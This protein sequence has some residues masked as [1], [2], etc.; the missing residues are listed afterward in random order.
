MPDDQQVG[1]DPDAF[2]QQFVSSQGATP[3]DPDE[4]HAKYASQAQPDAIGKQSK[5]AAIA[6]GVTNPGAA[7]IPTP[8]P[9]RPFGTRFKEFLGNVFNPPLRKPE[10]PYTEANPGPG[11]ATA[12]GTKIPLRD[13][14]SEA[15]SVASFGVGMGEGA[16]GMPRANI[17]GLVGDVASVSGEGAKAIGRGVS[18]TVKGVGDLASRAVREPGRYTADPSVPPTRG[19]LKP[20]AK[21]GVGPANISKF[22]DL[23]PAREPVV[24]PISHSPNYA[25]I[26]AGALRAGKPLA[27]AVPAPVGTLT[28]PESV[29]ALPQAALPG[30]AK[31]VTSSTGSMTSTGAVPQIQ[32]GKPPSEP[33]DPVAAAIKQGIA[34]KL[35]TRMPAQKAAAIAKGVGDISPRASE[36]TT[37]GSEGRAATWTNKKV[38]EEAGKGNRDAISQAIRR[39]LGLPDN[40]RYVMGEED[41]PRAVLNPREV[42]KFSPEGIPIRN[43][44]NPLAQNPSSRALLQKPEMPAARVEPQAPELTKA[45]RIGEGALKNRPEWTAQQFDA[46]ITRAKGILRNPEATPEDRLHAER[47]IESSREMQ[48]ATGKAGAIAKGV[49]Q[50]APNFRVTPP[51]ETPEVPKVRTPRPKAVP[52]SRQ[53]APDIIEQAENEMRGALEL[54]NSLPEAG[55]YFAENSFEEHPLPGRYN[56]K[57]GERPG[58]TWSGIGSQKGNIGDQYPWFNDPEISASKLRNAIQQGKGALYERIVGKIAEGI[59]KERGVATAAI[60]EDI[61]RLREL[62]EQVREIEPDLAQALSDLAD[63][64]TG[65]APEALKTYVKERI[66]D[67]T[68]AA[69]LSREIDEAAAEAR[70]AG[71]AETDE[72]SPPTRGTSGEAGPAAQ[73]PELNSPEGILPGMQNAVAQQRIAAGVEQGR[74]LTEKLDPPRF[75]SVFAVEPALRARPDRS[76]PRCSSPALET[77]GRDTP[78]A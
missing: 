18:S 48:G 41:L 66:S 60:S 26:R 70:Q 39:G 16:Q 68:E 72:A 73:A 75:H 36:P 29:S 43:A 22:A 54:S 58:G 27:E 2:H 71:P 46:E 35:P 78:S 59:T 57:A 33:I 13:A 19:A 38:W 56:V 63:G 20:W 64:K 30:I 9:D 24:Q 61:P 25:L 51:P 28:S 1:F 69:Q 44:E 23:A 53:Y 15:S 45:A 14:L 67:A 49:K 50:T 47:V 8:S 31:G 42:T 17:P 74:Q 62:A 4:F 3:F 55:R 10:A 5:A 6:A 7:P 12:P 52:A 76:P 37:S 40:A 21:I 32:I 11:E 34:A 77:C 65:L